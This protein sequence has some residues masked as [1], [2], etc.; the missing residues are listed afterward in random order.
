MATVFSDQLLNTISTYHID[1]DEFDLDE[2]LTLSFAENSNSAHCNNNSI[3]AASNSTCSSL[4][5]Q[6]MP[7]PV[8]AIDDVCAVCMEGLQSGGEEDHKIIGKQVP[9]GH[10]FH[11]TCISSWLVACNSCPL[12]RSP[13]IPAV[14]Q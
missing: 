5:V 13:M 14:E 10:V 2:A 11:A 1:L 8:T 9:C 4:I 12:C 7:S 3:I 6:C